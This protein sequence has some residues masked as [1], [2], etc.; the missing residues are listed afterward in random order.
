M[1]KLRKFF[2]IAIWVGAFVVLVYLIQTYGIEPL[3]NAVECM[4]IWAPLGIMLKG[5]NIGMSMAISLMFFILYYILI[6]GSEQLA[7]KNQLNPILSMWL[8]NIIILIFGG[9]WIFNSKNN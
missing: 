2:L 6:V 5:G 1:N 8:P 4:G 9:I 3:R 7:D